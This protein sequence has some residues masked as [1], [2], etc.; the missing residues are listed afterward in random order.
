MNPSATGSE[1]VQIAFLDS[2]CEA[3]LWLFLA[4]PGG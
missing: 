3:G 2:V 4:A 1:S